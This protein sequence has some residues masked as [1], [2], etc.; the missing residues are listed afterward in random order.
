MARSHVLK[1]GLLAVTFCGEPSSAVKWVTLQ[2]AAGRNRDLVCKKCATLM[3]AALVE[4]PHVHDPADPTTP[5]YGGAGD[6]LAC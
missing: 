2:T 4:P 3:D 1:P 5:R 6:G